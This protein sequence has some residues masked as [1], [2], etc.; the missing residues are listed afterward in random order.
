MKMLLQK[1]E[2][3]KGRGRDMLVELL[4]NGGKTGTV[5]L[6]RKKIQN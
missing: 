2:W 3:G 6:E 1:R 4:R 5:N